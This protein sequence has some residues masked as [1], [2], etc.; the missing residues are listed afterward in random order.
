VLADDQKRK[1][2]DELLPAQ[3]ETDAVY[4]ELRRVSHE[5]RDGVLDLFFD[6]ES[7]LFEL[8]RLYGVF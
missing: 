8:T 4:Q 7:G 1:A 5:F 3:Q 6:R 2:L